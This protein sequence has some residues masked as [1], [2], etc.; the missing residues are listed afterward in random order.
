MLQYFLI[1]KKNDIFLIVEEPEAHLYPDSQMLMADMLSLF[2]NKSKG[3][4]AGLIT[5]HSPY[6]L[7]ELNNLL[8]AGKVERSNQDRAKA[9]MDKRAWI[10]AKHFQALHVHGGGCENA[11]SDFGLIK[12]ELIDGASGEINARCDDLI[13]LLPEDDDA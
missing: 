2:I 3:H 11:V 7:G 6:I 10:E 5:T 13:A 12:N 1:E 4:N 9:I 8:L